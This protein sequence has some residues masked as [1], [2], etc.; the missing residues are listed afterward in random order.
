M[1]ISGFIDLLTG[2]TSPPYADRVHKDVLP[3]GYVLPAVV[4]HRYGSTQDYQYDGPLDVR[5]DQI[6][7]DIYG[8]DGDT[9]E[10]IFEYVRALLVGFT[11]TLPD[12]TVVLACYLERG[13]D[14]PFMANADQKSL[15]FRSTLGFRVISQV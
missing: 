4:L 14:M 8:G 13:M 5:E 12:G 3:R 9:A 15:A 11:G 6:Q 7:V 2:Q 10:T 1:M